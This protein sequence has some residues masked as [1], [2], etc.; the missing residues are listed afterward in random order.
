MEKIESFR[1]LPYQTH[2][3]KNGKKKSKNWVGKSNPIYEGNFICER[4]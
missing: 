3:N 4:K 2:N 1:E